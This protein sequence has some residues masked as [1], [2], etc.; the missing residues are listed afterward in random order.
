M[1][2][3]SFFRTA[4]CAG[5]DEIQASL[6]E[7]CLAHE[8]IIVPCRDGVPTYLPMEVTPPVLVDGDLIVHGGEKIAAHVEELIKFKG[9]WDKFQSDSCYV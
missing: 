4:D 7:L 8:L 6:E 5:C 2:M 9:L 3:I 1:N